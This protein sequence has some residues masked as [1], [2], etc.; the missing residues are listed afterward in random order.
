M[1]TDFEETG[2]LLEANRDETTINMDDGDLGKPEKQRRATGFTADA[3]DNDPL[4]SDDT[5]E[6]WTHILRCFVNHNLCVFALYCLQVF[7][8]NDVF[9]P[10]C[11][12]SPDKRK[13]P[14][15]GRLST[16]NSSLTLRPIT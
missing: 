11:S 16:T 13:V 2:S 1:K 6:V 14:L 7:A 5:T 8:L 4:G 9:F 12:F 3:D 15:S 10:H